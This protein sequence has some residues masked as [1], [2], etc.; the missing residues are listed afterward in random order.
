MQKAVS[1]PII[2]DEL[3]S[4]TDLT[5]DDNAHIEALHITDLQLSSIHA[6]SAS[7]DGV[8]FENCELS[9]SKLP[10]TSITDARFNSCML[11]AT[12]FD[13]SGWQRV[14]LKKGMMSGIVLSDTSLK[15]V[16]F[17]GIKINLA[18]FRFSNFERVRF[19]DCDLMEADFHQAEMK[20]VSFTGCDLRKADFSQCKMSDVDLRGSQLSELKGM[21]GLKG[22]IISSAQLFE[23]APDLADALG[24]RVSNE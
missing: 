5:L 19:E 18:N 8:V 14:E 11:F 22:S 1:I 24:M 4:S 20:S 9:A 23:L 6:K 12:D 21:Q 3:I 10:K 2:P 16:S 15:D 13:G 17:V 7:L